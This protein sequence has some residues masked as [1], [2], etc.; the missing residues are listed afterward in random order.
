MSG[1]FVLTSNEM[2]EINQIIY[3]YF[4]SIDDKTFSDVLFKEL[5][6]EDGQI[7]RPNGEPVIGS[8]NIFNS[9]KESFARFSATQH[10]VSNILVS[11]NKNEYLV[12]ANLQAMH[13]WNNEYQDKTSLD[14][15]F[16]ASSILRV[17]IQTE[18]EQM[19]ISELSVQP[20]WRSG[21]GYLT[22]LSTK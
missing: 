7:V 3:K 11:K 16:F 14:R 6:A 2:F 22:M 19:K 18:N 9:Q 4:S 8:T 10:V 12:R 20:I 1:N 17:K 21:S 5:F 13:I 15:S